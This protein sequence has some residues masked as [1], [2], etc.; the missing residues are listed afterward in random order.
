MKGPRKMGKRFTSMLVILLVI[1]ALFWFFFLR[2]KRSEGFR[3][4]VEDPK[5]PI[6]IK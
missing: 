3:E 1:L 2:S 4:G 6:M 5:K